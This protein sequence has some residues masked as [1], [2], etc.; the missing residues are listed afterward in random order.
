V[1]LLV[2]VVVVVVVVVLLLLLLLVVVYFLAVPVLVGRVGFAT[3]PLYF[4]RRTIASVVSL[5]TVFD[6]TYTHVLVST[7]QRKMVYANVNSR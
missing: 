4:H 7:T 6:S 1:L 3:V 5:L 2:V